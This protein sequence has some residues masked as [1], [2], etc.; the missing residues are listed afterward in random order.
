MLHT[1]SGTRARLV[2][3]FR[4]DKTDNSVKIATIEVLASSQK[5]CRMDL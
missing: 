2:G 3:A 5:Y 4:L 1:V